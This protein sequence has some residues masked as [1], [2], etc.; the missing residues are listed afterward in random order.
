MAGH[1]S[2]RGTHGIEPGGE[3][4]AHPVHEQVAEAAREQAHRQEEVG[5]FWSG[6]SPPP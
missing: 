3:G 1:Q 5:W 4:G 6:E 2:C